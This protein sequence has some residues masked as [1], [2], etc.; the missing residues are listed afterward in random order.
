MTK[1]EA[2]IWLSP[3]DRATLE[4]WISGRNTPQKLVWRA[5]IVLLSADRLGAMAI[6]RAVGHG[7]ADPVECDSCVLG[8]A[9]PDPPVQTFDLSDDRCPC[10]D[11]TPRISRQSACGLLRVLPAH[12]NVK[13]VGDR[14]LLAPSLDQYRPQTRAAVGERGHLSVCGSADRL[15][16]APDQRRDI[17]LVFATAPNTC[18]APSDVSTLPT[19][20]SRCRSPSR[21]LRMNVESTV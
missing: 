9:V 3:G 7:L 16:V 13:P 19:R 20:T 5:R 10:L 18:R 6:T 11:L 15:K 17:F 4:G 8:L 1:T 14:R 21:Q 12:G 2:S